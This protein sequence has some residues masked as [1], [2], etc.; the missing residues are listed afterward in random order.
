MKL[1]KSREDPPPLSPGVI[2]VLLGGWSAKS[3]SLESDDAVFDL[4]LRRNTGVAELWTAHKAFLLS[5]AQR[6]GIEPDFEMPDSR[7]LFF[8]EFL[9]RPPDEQTAYWQ[10]RSKEAL[11]DEEP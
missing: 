3:A 6:L 11:T 8:G 1:R 10:R 2:A 9:S 7:V 4:F 5:E